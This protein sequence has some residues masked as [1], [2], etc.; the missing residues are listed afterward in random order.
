M[1]GRGVAESFTFMG[2]RR[3]RPQ[4]PNMHLVASRGT[5]FAIPL[6]VSVSLLSSDGVLESYFEQHL[7]QYHNPPR[8]SHEL[9]D[10]SSLLLSANLPQ[11]I[12]ALIH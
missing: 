4:H 3:G 7:K 8:N 1:A 9:G 2:I 6:L 12:F 11:G 5:N 10:P